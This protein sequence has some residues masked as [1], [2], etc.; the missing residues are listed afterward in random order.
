MQDN[1]IVPS[2]R[3]GLQVRP[4]N[5]SVAVGAIIL[6]VGIGLRGWGVGAKSLW[7][8]EAFTHVV[9]AQPP[10]AIVATIRANDSHPPLYY[11]LA[12]LLVVRWPGEV[13]LRLLSVLAGVLA[14][15]GTYLLGRRLLGP[16]PAL[17]A[18][19]LVAISPAHIMASQEGRMYALMSL[20]VLFWWSVLWLATYTNRWWWVAYTVATVLALYTHYFSLVILA[21]QG[22]FVLSEGS[23]RPAFRA[24]VLA[25]AVGL[26]LFL[27]WVPSLVNQIA[28][29]RMLPAAHPPLA[30]LSVAEVGAL[31]QFGGGLYQTTPYIAHYRGDLALQYYPALLLPLLSALAAGII[32]L[33]SHRPQRAFL[34]SFLLVPLALLF[35]ASLGI[36]LFQ[37]RYFVILLPAYALLAAAGVESLAEAWHRLAGQGGWVRGFIVLWL[38]LFAA[39]GLQAYYTAP[40]WDGYDWRAGVRVVDARAGRAD[41]LAMIPGMIRIPYR[42]YSQHTHPTFLGDPALWLDPTRAQERAQYRPRLRAAAVQHDLWLLTLAALADPLASALTQDL[43]GVGGLGERLV[44]GDFVILRFSHNAKK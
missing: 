4:L 36:N 39:A 29:G 27:P 32:G 31:W 44:F 16:R 20:W 21:A 9:A 14:V 18:A 15:I 5:V 24:W 13:G 1:V 25:T 40:T 43:H 33:A 37:A 6:L 22:F 28:A 11:L 17:I 30:I 26:A 7:W 35:G 2:A 38:G 8:D 23:A 10:A 41:T 12:H 3:V 19:G 42:V 34:L